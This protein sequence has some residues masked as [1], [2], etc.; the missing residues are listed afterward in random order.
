MAVL[1]V[2]TEV[3]GPVKFFAAVAFPE[4]V[5]CC[6]VMDPL[7]PVLVRCCASHPSRSHRSGALEISPTITAR[8]G[9]TWTVSALVERL[10]VARE[11]FAAPAVTANVK[12]V[13]VSLRLV[14][15]LEAVATIQ[16]FVLLF[17]FMCAKKSC[18]LATF[19]HL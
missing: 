17:G 4:F 7:I 16:T 3:V 15:V 19:P 14:F 18:V 8:I 9:L 5:V 1:Q 2:L 12:A 6:E 13:L 10:T 11:R